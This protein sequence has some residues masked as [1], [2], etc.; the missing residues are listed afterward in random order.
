VV[1][2]ALSQGG[3]AAAQQ[4]TVDFTVS[5]NSTIRGWTCTVP[6]TAQVTTGQ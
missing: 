4:A 6:G 2:L 5:G 1:G 3:T